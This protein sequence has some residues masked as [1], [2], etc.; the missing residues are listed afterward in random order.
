MTAVVLLFQR[1]PSAR[2]G[3]EKGQEA[4][5]QE[6]VHWR[7]DLMKVISRMLPRSH[8]VKQKCSI[9]KKGYR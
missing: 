3:I 1:C 5:S 7:A 8:A 9:R 2:K 4:D 6:V